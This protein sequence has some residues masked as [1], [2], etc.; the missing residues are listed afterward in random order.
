MSHIFRKN[1]NTF[2]LNIYKIHLQYCYS[3][4]ERGE[5]ISVPV[6]YL[7]SYWFYQGVKITGD[8]AYSIICPFRFVDCNFTFLHKEFVFLNFIYRFLF[9]V[10]IVPNFF[11][12]CSHN[13]FSVF[14]FSVFFF[15]EKEQLDNTL[16]VSFMKII[17]F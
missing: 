14:F 3:P 9:L 8:S 13:S 2:F 17:Y 1:M 16:Y 10:F 6:L 5:T 12:Y 4:W 7:S 11:L 15:N